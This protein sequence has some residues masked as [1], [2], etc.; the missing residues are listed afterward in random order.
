MSDER[1]MLEFEFYANRSLLRNLNSN[2][3]QSFLVPDN[4]HPPAN[5]TWREQMSNYLWQKPPSYRVDIPI[6][7]CRW[8]ADDQRILI[9]I[10]EF[11]DETRRVLYRRQ[12]DGWW[13]GVVDTLMYRPLNIVRRHPE[14]TV[15]GLAFL[16]GILF[17][18]V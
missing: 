6:Q 9:R 1:K 15:I 5:A 17:F 16:I 3:S 14:W 11:P 10:E 13:A 8:E 12:F 7:K 4:E 18:R 2:A